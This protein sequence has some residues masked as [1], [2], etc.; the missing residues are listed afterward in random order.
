[1]YVGDTATDLGYTVE[2][3]RRLDVAV[4]GHARAI[5]NARRDDDLDRPVGQPPSLVFER[6][7]ILD[8][9]CGNC[10]TGAECKD[11][12]DS[13]FQIHLHVS[14]RSRSRAFESRGNFNP[15]GEAGIARCRDSDRQFRG[16]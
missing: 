4:A 2:R 13:A 5:R 11:Q 10:E 12:P 1:M 7:T 8:Q 16:Q 3:N 9:Q 14:H 15:G 6:R